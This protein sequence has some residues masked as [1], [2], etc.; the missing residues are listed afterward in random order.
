VG[1]PAAE[2]VAQSLYLRALRVEDDPSI[3]N[4]RSFLFRLARNAR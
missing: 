2:D 1:E 3:V 4:K